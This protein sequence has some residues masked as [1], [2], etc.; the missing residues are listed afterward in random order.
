MNRLA[1][2][3]IPTYNSSEY[4]SEAINSVLLQTY[5]ELEIIVID[6]GSTDTT[7]ETVK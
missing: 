5:N 7:E 6:D 3:I 1:S 2:V 4:I